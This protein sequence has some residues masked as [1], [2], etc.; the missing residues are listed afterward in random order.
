MEQ[1]VERIG[2]ATVN[3]L[4]TAHPDERPL[5]EEYFQANILFTS[6]MFGQEAANLLRRQGRVASKSEVMSKSA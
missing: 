5:V 1:F 6:I 3:R 4:R 2:D